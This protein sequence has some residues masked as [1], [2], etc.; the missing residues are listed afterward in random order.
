MGEEMRKPVLALDVDGVVALDANP[1]VPVERV[2]V[3]AYGRWRRE[4]LI[5]EGA[6]EL[7]ARLA[8]DYELVWATAWGSSAH[9]ALREALRLGD[10]P[11]PFVPVQFA[12]ADAVRRHAAGRPWV[13]VEEAMGEPG[14]QPDGVDGAI[15]RV[16]PTRGVADLDPDELRTIVSRLRPTEV[17][18]RRT[19]SPVAMV[20]E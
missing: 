17:D 19:V 16:S 14:Q 13:L 7:L 9:G 8:A 1:A 20:W 6:P 15:L 10:E 18:R 11:W 2:S 5:P 4:L 12:K 3:S